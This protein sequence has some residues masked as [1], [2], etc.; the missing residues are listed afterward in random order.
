VLKGNVEAVRFLVEEAH[1][2]VNRK[3]VFGRLPL[4]NAVELNMD[5]IAQILLQNCK[6]TNLLAGKLDCILPYDV[7][8]NNL[9]NCKMNCG[10]GK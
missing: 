4:E 2:N 9:I 5:S 10:G 1:V 7:N 8:R 6:T 3:D